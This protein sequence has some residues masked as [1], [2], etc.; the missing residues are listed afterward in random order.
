V[1]TNDEKLRSYLEEHRA[2]EDGAYAIELRSGNSRW[3]YPRI[4]RTDAKW[5]YHDANQEVPRSPD[6]SQV[7]GPLVPEVYITHA[8]SDPMRR[9]QRMRDVD[10]PVLDHL[11]NDESTPLDE[12]AQ[13]IWFL[14][15]THEAIADEKPRTPGG[16]WLSHKM[17]A[18]SLYWRRYELGGPDETKTNYALFRF[19]NVAEQIGLYGDEELLRRLQPLAQAQPKLP[20]VW[21]MIAAHAAR[22]DARRGLV[23]AE[24]AAKVASESKGATLHV[25]TDGRVEWYALRL[26]AACA[27]E[28][29]LDRR[30]RELAERAVAAGGPPDEFRVYLEAA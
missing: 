6:G 17:A 1:L 15:Q 4:L 29:K 12:R 3:L 13:P 2:A 24:E 25:P 23:L 8:V 9:V 14:A 19:L 26:A 28:L 7:T 16:P 11:A 27:K 30:A 21:Y 5:R 22:L 18:M 10:L 20:E